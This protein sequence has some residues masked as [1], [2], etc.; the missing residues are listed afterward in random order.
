MAFDPDE[1]VELHR[2]GPMTLLAAVERVMAQKLQG[3]EA[4]IT[5]D[6]EPTILD[7]T[8]IEK[9]VAEWKIG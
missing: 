1:I 9:I 2:Q 5:R 6:G 3:L 7:L 8:Q 4:T